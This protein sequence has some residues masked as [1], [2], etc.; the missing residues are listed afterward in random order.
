MNQLVDGKMTRKS[1]IGGNVNIFDEKPFEAKLRLILVK[2]VP[3]A[4]VKQVVWTLDRLIR[5]KQLLGSCFPKASSLRQ[6][7]FQNP[8][9]VFRLLNL[10]T[11]VKC[12]ET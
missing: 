11:T 10:S 9:R 6:I 3:A 8:L 1:D 5:R 4:A 7:R 2:I 12:A